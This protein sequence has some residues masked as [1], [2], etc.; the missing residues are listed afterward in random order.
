MVRKVIDMLSAVLRVTTESAAWQLPKEANLVI[1]GL[2][3]AAAL[4]ASAAR[5]QDAPIPVATGYVCR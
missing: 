4:T 5:A 1:G 3:L 2:A